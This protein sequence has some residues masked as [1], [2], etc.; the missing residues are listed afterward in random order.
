MN[1]PARLFLLVGSLFPS[2][3]AEPAYW[4]FQ[5]IRRPD[6]PPSSAADRVRTPIDAFLLPALRAKR[7]AFNP[8]ADK[9][10]LIRRASFDLTGLPPAA[11]DVAAY[12]NDSSEGA[13]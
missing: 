3:A 6:P 10:T 8:D 13:Y 7:L 11:V 1:Q 12:V 5:P 2:L 4:F 9:L